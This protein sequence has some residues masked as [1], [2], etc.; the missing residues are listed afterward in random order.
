MYQIAGEGLQADSVK[1][2]TYTNG[3][4]YSMLPLADVEKLVSAY[5][6]DMENLDFSLLRN[7]YPCG[8]LTFNFGNFR[9]STYPVYENYDN[10]LTYLQEQ[11]VYYPVE[12]NAEDI[13]CIT[14][15]NYHNEE[16][17]TFDGVWYDEEYVADVVSAE[18]E[19][20]VESTTVSE[21]FY[22]QEQIAQILP[23]IY[24][25]N[26]WSNWHKDGEFDSNYEVDIEFKSD[27]SY[28]YNKSQYYF[29]YEFFTG[30]VPDFVVEATA[31]R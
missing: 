22:E 23:Y 12:L 18:Y 24:P 27:T 8:K 28:P 10:V 1:S 13:N 14:I 15:T 30:Q 7:Q 17:E 19:L 16:T 5:V 29:S 11:N 6:K 2:V 21:T 25:S 31:L 20:D 9:S 4:T 3:A 26:I